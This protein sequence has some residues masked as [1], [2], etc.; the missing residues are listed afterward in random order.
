M[1][2]SVKKIVDSRLKSK[3]DYG[4]DLLGIML[5][6]SLSIEEIIDEC[7]S[8]FFAGYENNS[9]LLTWTTMLL[10]LHQDW[11]EKLRE[12]IFKECGK[13]KTPDSDTFSKLKL[14]NM[15]FMESLRLYGPVPFTSRQTSKDLTL[16]HLEIP[17]GTTLIFPLMKMHNDKVIWGSDADKFNPQRFE[18]GVSKAANHPNALVS[19]SIGPRACIGQNFAMIEAK[20][21]LTMILQRFRLNLSCQ[22][23]H[24]PV[25]HITLLPQYGLPLVLQPLD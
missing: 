15:V 2:N 4:D 9:N 14:M 21:V 1:K 7:K 17:K 8:F 18:N 20:T 3:P 23:K 13:D 11:Q 5:K 12:E 24:A 16:G 22:Y 10:S 19:F 25:D 6:S